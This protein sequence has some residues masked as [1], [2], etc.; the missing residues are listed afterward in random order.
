[1]QIFT[2]W[3]P[4][5]VGSLEKQNNCKINS[6]K[7]ASITLAPP[8][9]AMA[10]LVLENQRNQKPQNKEKWWYNTS[11]G[12]NAWKLPEESPYVKGNV[13]TLKNLESPGND[14]NRCTE[15]EW[16]LHTLHGFIL[17]YLRYVYTPVS[18]TI[19]FTV[20]ASLSH[21]RMSHMPEGKCHRHTKFFFINLDVSLLSHWQPIFTITNPKMRK[22]TVF[23]DEL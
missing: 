1:M 22:S 16:S 11:S 8:I 6:F 19:P 17:H 4:L 10:F 13:K 14:N 7:K 2:D 5:L 21:P 12:W 18:P 15:E 9:R 23:I 20:R 3:E